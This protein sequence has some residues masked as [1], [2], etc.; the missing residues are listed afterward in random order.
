MLEP[1]AGTKYIFQGIK[2]LPKVHIRQRQRDF[3][4]HPSNLAS[5][6]VPLRQVWTHPAPTRDSGSEDRG[7]QA[8]TLYDPLNTQPLVQASPHE[9]LGHLKF[10]ICT[11][12]EF[13]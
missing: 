6:H 12:Q 8:L 10:L 11:M 9:L 4:E 7:L 13:E 5:K 3:C 1:P 2:L